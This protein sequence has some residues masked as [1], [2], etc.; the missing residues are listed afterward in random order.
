M[1]SQPKRAPNFQ[2]LHSIFIFV[3]VI[4][5]IPFVSSSDSTVAR[6]S[7]AT[8][9]VAKQSEEIAL[10]K[11][12]ASLDNQSQFLLSSWNET[13]HCTWVGIGCNDASKV[14]NLT[15]ASIGLR[16]I[17]SIW[18]ARNQLFF[19]N[20]AVFW[21][22]VIELTKARVAFCV[23]RSGNGWVCGSVSLFNSSVGRAKRFLGLSIEAVIDG[24]NLRIC[25]KLHLISDRRL[26]VGN[27]LHLKVCVSFVSSLTNSSQINLLEG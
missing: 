7:P 17:W 18:N 2:A 27:S 11:W 22:E 25:L 26:K 6:A 9:T 13:S 21:V 24:A 14:T 15:L 8:N 3:F 19:E 10:L 20:E 1:A 4:I 16:V 12:K 23:T 5:L